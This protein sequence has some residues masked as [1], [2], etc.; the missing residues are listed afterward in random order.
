MKKPLLILLPAV[1]LAAGIGWYVRS[2]PERPVAAP[3][4][5]VPQKGPP[6]TRTLTDGA[7]I[8]KKAFWREPVAADQIQHAERQEWSDAE[9]ITRWAW[10][11]EVNASPELVKYL[12]ED[13]SFGLTPAQ[14]AKLPEGQPS[15]FSFEPGA[16]SVLNSR[17][18]NLQLIFSNQ[19]NRLLACD[20]GHGFQRG[21]AAPA[22][23]TDNP[24][25]RP[26]PLPGRLPTTPPPNPN[27]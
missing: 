2:L 13:N 5:A 19:D 15:W 17:R 21:A 4:V 9:G 12:R 14:S 10:F 1:L 11:L 7:A 3:A 18:G 8:F 23:A 6:P 25:T 20:S 16:V 27:P 26:A 24:A 22:A